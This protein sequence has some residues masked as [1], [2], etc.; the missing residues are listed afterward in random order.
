MAFGLAQL[1]SGWL[2]LAWL[3]LAWLGSLYGWQLECTRDC[4]AG[5]QQLGRGMTRVWQGRRVWAEESACCGG[6]CSQHPVQGVELGCIG[7]GWIALCCCA[8]VLYF[9][10]G[11]GCRTGL[12][13]C[14]GVFLCVFFLNLQPP[15]ALWL[16]FLR[17]QALRGQN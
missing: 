7:L 10:V 9:R 17:R 8:V 11:L 3:D 14:V 16:R 5:R 4:L 1:G 2:G 12:L 15:G 6:E 13:G